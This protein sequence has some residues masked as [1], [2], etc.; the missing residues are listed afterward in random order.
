M[1]IWLVLLTGMALGIRHAFDRDHITAV[2]HFI[3]LE[4]DARKSA[5]FGARWALG[6]AASV[7]AFGS[8]ILLLGIKLTGAFERYAE[9][10]VGVSLIVLA[11]WRLLLLVQERA[12]KHRHRHDSLMHQHA[13]T[14]TPTAR[15]VHPY[16]PVLVGLLHGAAGT[17]EI[18]VL[19]PISLMAS[20]W[21]AYSYMA[22]FSAGCVVSMS[23]Y[24]YFAGRIYG[25]ANLAGGQ[26][27][28]VVVV[29]TS[30]AGLI[31]GVIWIARN[32]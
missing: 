13:H 21:L 20:R 5:W 4:P 7:F 26:L 12:H 6:H 11:V 1:P 3:S 10:A 14:H 29:L 23:S 2:T 8:I 28:R 16:A 22:L 19:I 31:L 18:F 9:L 17:M 27:Y 32:L 15:H 30:A 25:R 24:G